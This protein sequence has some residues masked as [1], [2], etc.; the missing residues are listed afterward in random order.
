[1]PR[2]SST[3]GGSEP[4]FAPQGTAHEA[5]AWAQPNPSE[6]WPTAGAGLGK[7]VLSLFKKTNIFFPSSPERRKFLPVCFLGTCKE[8][9]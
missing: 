2:L 4:G 5:E 3:S 7:D 1:M 8:G 9:G 6:C